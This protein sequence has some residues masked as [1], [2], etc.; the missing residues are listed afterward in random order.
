[1]EILADLPAKGFWFLS[2]CDSQQSVQGF[3]LSPGIRRI[4][5]RRAWLR[6]E[7]MKKAEIEEEDKSTTQH[8]VHA[9]NRW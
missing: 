8:F 9:W 6:E 4:I 7:V 2:I 1:V 5:L 3:A